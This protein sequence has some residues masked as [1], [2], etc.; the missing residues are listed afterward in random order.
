MN[1]WLVSIF[2]QT[3]IDNVFS[4]RF[5]SIAE[6]ALKRGHTVTFFGSTFKHNTKN[7]RFPETT[8]ISPEKDYKIVFIES[9]SY[10]TNISPKRLWS[11]HKFA[12]EAIKEFD[13]HDRPDV[14]LLAFPPISLAYRLSQWANEKKI[15]LVMDIIDP[16]PD[17]FE[18]AIPKEVSFLSPILFDQPRRRFKKILSRVT[19]LTA[20]SNQYINWALEYENDIPKVECLYPATDYEAVRKMI[21]GFNKSKVE[22]AKKFNVIYAGSLASSYDLPCILNAAQKL[23]LHDDI[24]IFIAGAGYQEDLI[25]KYVQN[26][27]N[28]TFLGRLEKKKLM[29][30]YS[31]C[32]VGLTQHIKGATQSVTYKLFDLLAA[33]LPILNSLES[34]MKDIIVDNRVGFHNSPG[35]ATELAD[36]I[37]K[38]YN[39]N[40]L[41]EVY[42]SNALN[43]AETIGNTSV[44]Y[45]RFVDILE[46]EAI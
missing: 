26:H 29:E 42:K 33:G 1:I 10:S 11:H 24:H 20:I 38:L 8:V 43:L 27:N 35:D 21:N 46:K 3:P 18:K 23:Y 2:E 45:K 14:I 9:K 19:M 15:P 32:D 31:I 44:I 34:E 25:Q 22:K 41:L 39:T 17:I 12:I 4:T 37:L 16:W 7:Q 13:R 5:I 40:G 30:Y 36:N 28:V 6:E